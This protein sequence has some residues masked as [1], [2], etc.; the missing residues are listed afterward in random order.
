MISQLR[1]SLPLFL[2][3][4]YC[5]KMNKQKAL[6]RKMCSLLLEIKASY[7]YV[8]IYISS[9]IL[10]LNLIFRLCGFQLT[11][12][13]TCLTNVSW[14]CFISYGAR[15]S[16]PQMT[17]K[18]AVRQMSQNIICF[19]TECAGYCRDIDKCYSLTVAASN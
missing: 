1:N 9:V 10:H 6:K 15:L 5:H 4:Y 18:S 8:C 3:F 11:M 13:I 12:A 16:Y 17:S 2:M 19:S 7:M 14:H